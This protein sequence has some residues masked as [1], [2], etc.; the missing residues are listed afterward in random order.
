MIQQSLDNIH[1]RD[2]VEDRM[3]QGRCQELDEFLKH[4]KE[5][6]SNLKR[7]QEPQKSMTS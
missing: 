4:V 6:E 7:M 2:G 1:Q 3:M 5:A